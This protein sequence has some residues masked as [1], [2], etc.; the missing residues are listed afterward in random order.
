MTMSKFTEEK[1]FQRLEKKIRRAEKEM[2]RIFLEDDDFDVYL[3]GENP[4][5][6]MNN[7]EKGSLGEFVFNKFLNEKKIKFQRVNRFG[8]DFEI[9]IN[10]RKN[11]ID[12]KTSSKYKIWKNKKY[13]KNDVYYDVIFIDENNEG[14]P[15]LLYPDIRSPLHKKFYGYKLG[16]LSD[17]RNKFDE[18]KFLTTSKNNKYDPSY[19]FKNK[20]K[21]LGKNIRI[22]YRVDT[23]D[24]KGFPDNLPG[25]YKKYDATVFLR[26]KFDWNKDKPI[27]EEGFLLLSKD[28]DRN[29]YPLT[30]AQKRQKNK[31]IEKVINWEDFRNRFRDLCF[32]EEDKLLLE[33]EKI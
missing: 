12:L 1:E 17:L 31:G 4:N 9:E 24:W 5:T 11:K 7:Q 18:S 15:V 16:D 26:L 32:K 33:I 6:K 14:N 25:S 22:L 21:K 29:K 8:R 10:G 27:F 28:L 20:I 13:A 23:H 19:S 3:R 30:D 2:S